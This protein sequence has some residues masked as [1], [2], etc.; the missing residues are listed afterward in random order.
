MD[1]E[2]GFFDPEWEYMFLIGFFIGGICGI[3]CLY[4]A[5]H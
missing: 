1:K 3:A 5:Q 2:K 4:F